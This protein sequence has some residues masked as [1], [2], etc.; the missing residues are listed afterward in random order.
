MKDSARYVKRVEWSDEDGC[1]VGSCPGVIGPCCHGDD[2]VAVYREL[3]GIVDEWLEALR[4]EGRAL[5]ERTA[6]RRDGGAAV[7]ECAAK[8]SRLN[9]QELREIARTA[10]KRQFGN[11][12]IV[13]INIR[14]GFGFE[15]DSP[16][17]DVSIVYNDESGKVT[18]YGC[19]LTRTELIDK[20][21]REGKDELGY[22]CVNFIA[23]SGLGQRDPATV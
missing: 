20:T 8:G 6:G 3:C 7:C 9:E 11:I 16:I 21:W 4:A 2:E 1:F 15:D 14:Q 5:P 10:F 23:K 18:G 17:V 22:P 12:D 13:R 19:A